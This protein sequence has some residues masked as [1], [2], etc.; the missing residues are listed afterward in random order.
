M[1]D[2]KQLLAQFDWAAS[3]LGPR[4]LWPVGMNAVVGRRPD[5]VK[6]EPFRFD[7]MRPG[8]FDVDARVRRCCEICRVRKPITALVEH[9]RLLCDPPDLAELGLV[10][11]K[12]LALLP[13]AASKRNR[14]N[15]LIL[16]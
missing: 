4:S 10:H 5:T 11:A 14:L 15:H 7:Q 16:A 1:S 6:V 9:L 2:N 3:P 12:A 8:C 13:Q